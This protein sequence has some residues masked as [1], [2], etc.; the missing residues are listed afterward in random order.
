MVQH[1]K[2]HKPKHNWNL[3]DVIILN[4]GSTITVKYTNTDL[5][6]N[7]K[8]IKSPL[9]T[10]FGHQEMSLLDRWLMERLVVVWYVVVVVSASFSSWGSTQSYAFSWSSKPRVRCTLLLVAHSIGCDDRGKKVIWRKLWGILMQKVLRIKYKVD[11]T[12][13]KAII[14]NTKSHYNTVQPLCSLALSVL[15][16]VFVRAGFLQNPKKQGHFLMTKPSM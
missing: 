6:T 12:P 2:H 5:V 16:T 13:V 11:I 10:R 3:D 8:P 4:Y 14:S 9:H 15:C 7:I 1:K